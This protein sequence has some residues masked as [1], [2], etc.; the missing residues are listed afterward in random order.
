MTGAVMPLVS[1]GGTTEPGTVSLTWLLNG[2][3]AELGA[4]AAYAANF[5]SID[6]GPPN[7]ADVSA[8][9]TFAG[10]SPRSLSYPTGLTVPAGS[11]PVIVITLAGGPTS[12]NPTS[13]T[14]GGQPF[15]LRNLLYPGVAPDFLTQHLTVGMLPM[16]GGLPVSNTLTVTWAGANAF[17]LRARMHLLSFV[18]ASSDDFGDGYAPNTEG[19]NGFGHFTIDVSSSP[20]DL[21]ITGVFSCLTEST[22][23][24]V[25]FTGAGNSFIASNPYNVAYKVT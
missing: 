4:P 6:S 7:V 23:P 21:V 11:N 14:F 22:D 8:S 24:P 9:V 3:G 25:D 18:A 10:S 20:N 19:V 16:R 2:D 1:Y 12:S 17:T 15:T 5:V 13:I